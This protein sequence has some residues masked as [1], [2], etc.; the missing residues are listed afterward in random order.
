MNG[1]WLSAE[2]SFLILFLDLK[3]NETVDMSKVI[4]TYIMTVFNFAHK[5]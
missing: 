2:N 3:K 1:R 5:V 4:F